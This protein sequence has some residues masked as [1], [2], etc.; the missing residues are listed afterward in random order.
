M[1]RIVILIAGLLLA[2]SA[3]AGPNWQVTS[4]ATD[5][6]NVPK[7]VAMTDKLM[8][9]EAGKEMPGTVTLMVNTVD[10][11]SPSTHSFITSFDSQAQREAFFQK[12]TAD[13]AWE[14]FQKSFTPITDRGSVSRMTF[15]N[16]WGG[17]DANTDVVW[18]IYALKVSD[19]D[20]YTAALEKFLAS[21]TGKKFPG[22][23]YLSRVDAAGASTSTHLVSVGY[24]SEAEAET[25]GDMAATTADWSAFM[26][27]IRKVSEPNGTWIIR[28]LKTWG[29]VEE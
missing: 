29:S 4:F 25:W 23:I 11:N 6:Q 15:L 14:K 2:Q 3:F 18:Q 12:L 1:Q 10:G 8:A 22:S 28:T 13:P 26:Q 5:P 7:I 16:D 20:A 17:D 24:Q 19:A 9:S 27:A 21:E